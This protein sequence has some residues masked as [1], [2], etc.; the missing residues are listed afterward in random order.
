MSGAIAQ[1]RFAP[2]RTDVEAQH[3]SDARMI[4]AARGARFIA[5]MRRGHYGSR[6]VFQRWMPRAIVGCIPFVGNVVASIDPLPIFRHPCRCLHDDIAD[7]KV[8]TASSSAKATLYGDHGDA[9]A[10]LRTISF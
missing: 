10:D 4:D 9:G 5:E 1:N 2:P 3:D 6:F 8:V 7:T